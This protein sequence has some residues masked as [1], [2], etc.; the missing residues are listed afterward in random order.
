METRSG[1]TADP[2]PESN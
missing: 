2:D 1:I